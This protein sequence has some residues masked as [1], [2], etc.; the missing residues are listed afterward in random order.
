METEPIAYSPLTK[1]L[2]LKIFSF[3]NGADL[4]HK[5]ALI[6]KDLRKGLINKGLL[7]QDKVV[8]LSLSSI[9]TIK[10]FH[11]TYSLSL[12]DAVKITL[13]NDHFQN[14]INKKVVRW[15]LLRNKIQ[16]KKTRLDFAVSRNSFFSLFITDVL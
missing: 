12:V 16:P 11:L 7:D 2:K 5:I 4:I 15:I 14:E 8:N 13:T 6:S 1:G 3:L 10:C 9:D